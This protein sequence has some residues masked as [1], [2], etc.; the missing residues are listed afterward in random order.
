MTGFTDGN[1]SAA[2]IRRIEGLLQR[3]QLPE[4]RT[5]CDS[6]LMRDPDNTDGWLVAARI[7]QQSGDYRG[8]LDAARRAL[9]LDPSNNLARFTEIEARMHAGDVAGA[10]SRLSDIESSA[11]ADSTLETR[12]SA[13][14]RSARRWACSTSR[15]C[16]T[17]IAAWSPSSSSSQASSSS[18]DCP[19]S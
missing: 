13:R 9:Q 12:W 18:N 1:D 16:S 2:D 15:A 5:L 6:L 11:G 14:S 19:G 10:R 4:A 8:M 3:R 7:C 17:A